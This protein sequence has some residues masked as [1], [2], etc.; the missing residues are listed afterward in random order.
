MKIGRK[1]RASR[2]DSLRQ[3]IEAKLPS[4][5]P[6]KKRASRTRVALRR[7]LLA[8][9]FAVVMMLTMVGKPKSAYAIFDP[10]PEIDPGS[11]AGAMTL[12]VGGCL[13]LTGRVRR[14]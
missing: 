11:M 3:V 14:V 13:S 6:G 1:R 4:T 7:A 8:T 10:V 2:R 9:S 12:L 5:V